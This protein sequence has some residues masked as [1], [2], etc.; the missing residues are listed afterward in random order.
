MARAN[1]IADFQ[2]LL[3]QFTAVLDEKFRIQSTPIGYFKISS[4]LANY[5]SET[6]RVKRTRFLRFHNI[7][8]SLKSLESTSSRSYLR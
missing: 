1:P 3:V 4:I 5:N 8:S 2:G 6:I 7:Q